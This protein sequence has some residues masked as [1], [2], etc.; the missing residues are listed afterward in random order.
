M[1]RRKFLV[2]IVC[3]TVGVVFSV[4]TPMDDVPK[5]TRGIWVDKSDVY[6]GKEYLSDKFKA[7]K[8]ANFNMV[9][10]PTMHKGYV[11]YPKSAYLPLDPGIQKIDENML[12]WI[13]NEA[14]KH[15]LFVEAWPEYGFYCYHTMNA[16]TD[17]SRGVLLDKNPE[18]AAVDIKG[19]PYLHNK[20]WGDF[21]SLCPANPESHKILTGLFVEMI[22]RYQFDGINTDRIRF[23][24]KDFCFCAY[25]KEHFQKDT[26]KALTSEFLKSD[27]GLALFYSWRK[28]QLN[29]FMARL[30]KKLRSVRPDI[31]ITADVW[32]PDD[33]Q[34]NE[35]GQDW[36]TWLKQGNIDVAIPM[37]YWKNIEKTVDGCLKLSADPKR[38]VCGISAEVNNSREL[39]KQIELCREK[40]AGGVVIWYLGKTL[41]DLDLLK[42]TVFAKPA[43]PGYGGE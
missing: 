9:C 35:K 5:E 21:Y 31:V 34:I 38:I 10:L 40:G 39:V 4:D 19:T 17:T 8:A 27:D 7:L 11:A 13:I 37:M 12:A 23:H 33:N 1:M 24:T 29:A 43:M 30:A 20:K 16:T 22:S 26:G 14:H 6:K 2:I 42:K 36:G 18:L 41:D 15:G 25:C 28:K 3:L 32:P